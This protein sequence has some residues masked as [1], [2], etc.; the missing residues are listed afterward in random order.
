MSRKRAADRWSLR[1]FLPR[2]SLFTVGKAQKSHGARSESNSMFGLEKVDRWNPISTSTIQSRSRPHAISGLLQ[3]WKGRDARNFEVINGLQH[4]FEKWVERCKK[5]IASQGRY[6]EKTPS[7]HLHKVPTRS[8]K[9]SPRTFQTAFVSDVTQHMDNTD[10]HLSSSAELLMA[11]KYKLLE[12]VPFC[13]KI[14]GNSFGRHRNLKFVGSWLTSE[15]LRTKNL[16]LGDIY[17]FL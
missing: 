6:F 1:N 17:H 3:L 9:V 10:L 12:N 4:V 2:S 13:F 15:Q 16:N 5:C 14:W 11:A 7:P 8:N